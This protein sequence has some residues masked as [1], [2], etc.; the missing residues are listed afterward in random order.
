MAGTLELG[1]TTIRPGQRVSLELPAASLYTDTPVTVPVHVVNG[2]RDGPTV[3]VSAAIHGDELNGVEIIRRLLRRSRLRHLRGT[4]IAVPVVNVFGFIARS[5]YLPDRRDLNRS[6]PGSEKGS[7]AARLAHLFVEEIVSHADY[8]IDLHTGALQ[9]TNLPQVRTSLDD[10]D[11]LRLARAFGAPLALHSDVRDG[12][13][14]GYCTEEGVPTLL[15]EAGEALRF[16]EVAIRTGVRGILAVLESLEML[17]PTRR[18]AKRPETVLSRSSQWLRAPAGGIL[19]SGPRLGQWLHEGDR[20]GVVTDPL[21]ENQVG[22]VAPF[23]GI[24]IGAVTSPLVNEGD[25]LYH[26]AR[27]GVDEAEFSDRIQD[28]VAGM[29]RPSDPGQIAP[30]VEDPGGRDEPR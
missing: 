28:L 30:P 9:R 4:L 22:V 19:Q 12:S 25:A 18:V 29:D 7:L 10:P 11:C 26:V 1:G 14:R 8:G 5:R 2:R 24:V 23:S 27:A 16:S 21:G 13:L 6:F 20:V 3:F 15:Y 17:R